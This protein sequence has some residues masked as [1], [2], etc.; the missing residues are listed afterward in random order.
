M[1]VRNNFKKG[2]SSAQ[3]YR[4]AGLYTHIMWGSSPVL[5]FLQDGGE[6]FL[7]QESEVF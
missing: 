2:A 1:A 5:Q 4:V 7:E 3:I 6:L